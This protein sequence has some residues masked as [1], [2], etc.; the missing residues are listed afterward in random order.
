M[1][2]PI[3]AAVALRVFLVIVELPDVSSVIQLLTTLRKLMGHPRSRSQV[4]RRK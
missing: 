1:H 3:A 4:Y 2:R